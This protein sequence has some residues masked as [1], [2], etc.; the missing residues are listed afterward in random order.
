VLIR[1]GTLAG[2]ARPL[3][4]RL[5]RRAIGA[6]RGDLRRIEFEHIESVLRLAEEKE[7]RGGIRLPGVMVSRSF[8]WLRLARPAEGPP[9]EYAMPLPVPGEVQLPGGL[10]VAARLH[11]G[12]VPAGG[13]DWEAVPKPLGVRSWRPGDRYQPAGRPGPVKLKDL[14]QMHRIPAWDRPGWPVAVAGGAILWARRFGPAAAFAARAGT[15][16][17]LEFEVNEQLADCADHG[18]QIWRLNK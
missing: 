10:R 14:F 4:R 8:D 3:A 11:A 9:A 1:T 17:V 16:A 2:L 5:V 7:G 13:L 12:A 18:A 6:G 15:E